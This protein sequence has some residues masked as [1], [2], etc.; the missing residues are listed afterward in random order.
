MYLNN[1][2]RCA[3]INS[4]DYNRLFPSNLV[5]LF[6]NEC[7]CKYKGEFDLHE[8]EPVGETHPRVDI[9]TNSKKFGGSI[10]F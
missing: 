2:Q 9:K 4:R 5:P 10:T 7:S 3:I 8:S 1:E 6:G